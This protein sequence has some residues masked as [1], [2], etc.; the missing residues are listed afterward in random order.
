MRELGRAIENELTEPCVPERHK[1]PALDRRHDLAG[2][3]QLARDLHGRGLRH[4]F[5][6]TVEAHFEENI[7]LDRIVH[8]HAAGLLRLEHVDNRRQFFVF[9][10]DFGRDVLGFGARIGH[11]HRDQFADVADLVDHQGRLLR[12]LKPRQRR[13]RAD[14]LD[15]GQVLGGENRGSQMLGNTNAGEARM[16]HRAA[17][18]RHLAH[19]REPDIRNVLAAA[20]KETIVLLSPQPRTYA[21]LAQGLVSIPL[22][23]R[24]Q[25]TMVL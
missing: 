16:R 5:D 8:E 10:D 13:N 2:G 21:G 25:R 23:L 11:A 18:K 14:R 12:D 4:R 22:V 24:M 20:V 9:D 19:A 6:G 3:A 1:T 7:S 15:A 17:D